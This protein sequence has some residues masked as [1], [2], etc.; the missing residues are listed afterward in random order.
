MSSGPHDIEIAAHEKEYANGFPLVAAFIAEDKDKTSTVYRRFDRLAARNLLYLQS[1]LIQLE[2]KQDR[3]DA[4]DLQD[5]DLEAKRA[6]TSWE[7][8]EASSTV[9]EREKWRMETAEAIQKTLKEYHEALL[10]HSGVLKLEAPANRTLKAFKDWFGN[11]N[12][13]NTRLRGQSSHILD[14]END[15]I[16]LRIPAEQDRLTKLVQRYFPLLFMTEA[17]PG[18]I[19]YISEKR[20]ARFV[21][22]FST[23]LAAVLLIGAIILL[24]NI[25]SQNWRM[26]IIAI[27]MVLFAASVGL[28]TSARRAEIFA[29]TAA[30]AAVLVVFVSGNFRPV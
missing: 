14:D 27:F 8:F 13:G 2:A 6:A 21:A 11:P 22:V 29:A 16:A 7:D 1:R 12:E 25:Q 5:G 26:A 28:L 23:V 4:E 20:L 19:A 15:L 30:Y 18:S 3:Y 9:R 10:L 17:G 24:Y